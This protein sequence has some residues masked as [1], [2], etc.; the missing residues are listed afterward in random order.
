VRR[1]HVSDLKPDM[2]L[3]RAIFNDTGHLLLGAGVPI[4]ERY[5][6][7]LQA[8]GFAYVDVED[9]DTDDLEMND[10][11]SERTR[12]NVT[13]DT[14]RILS[15][16]EGVT[17]A[18]QGQDFATLQNEISSDDFGRLA[19]DEFGYEDLVA[20]LSNVVDE[21]YGQTLLPG[22]ATIRSYDSYLFLHSIDTTV[23]AVMIGKKLGFDR[24]RLHQLAAGAILHD[25]GMVT[26]DRQIVQ[27]AGRLTPTEMNAIRQHPRLGYDMLRQVRPRDVIPNHV[28]YQHHERQDGTGYPRGLQGS[29]RVTRSELE[30]HK[31]GRILL[32]A[33]I[34]A[35]ADVYDALGADRPFRAALPPDQVVRMMRALAGTHLNREIV[36]HLLQMLPVYPLGSEIVVQNGPYARYRGVVCR[37]DRNSLEHPVVRLLFD[38]RGERIDPVEVDLRR[39]SSIVIASAP[40]ARGE[41]APSRDAARA[42]AAS[43]AQPAEPAPVRRIPPV[44]PQQ[45]AQIEGARPAY[46]LHEDDNAPHTGRVLVV[47]DDPAILE[48]LQEALQDAGHTVLG[49][50]SGREALS[51]AGSSDLMLLDLGLPDMDGIDVCRALRS[52]SQ[53]ELNRLPVM[54]L[55]ARGDPLDRVR[56]IRSGADDYLA[57]PFDLAEVLVRVE[58]LLRSRQ[59][60]QALRERNRQLDALRGLIGS[61][62]EEVP[63]AQ[64]A[65]RMVDV[66]PRAFGP[67][68]GVLGAVLS[69]VDRRKGT[70]RG[71]ALTEIPS[72]HRALEMLR[73]PLTTVGSRFDPPQNLQH[74]AALTGELRAGEHLAEFVSPTLA[75]DLAGLIERTIGMKGGVAQPAK[76]HGETIALFLFLLAKPV[77]AVSATERQLMAELAQTAAVPLENARLHA[78]VEAVGGA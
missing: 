29:G 7:I 69:V 75:P 64:L 6:P 46:A 35:V 10:I 14:Y 55:T 57:K 2:V 22:L 24:N 28:A 20:D 19:R 3:A 52:A 16:M 5:I 32:D 30:K 49:A 26:V 42:P 11:I 9:P 1:I 78:A 41:A 43:A 72:A 77:T 48:V 44:A 58:A 17:R 12:L 37:V 67:D 63:V 53:P 76:S 70:I 74:Q 50:T 51:L 8:R 40:V 61:L 38:P 66:V 15:S 45:P 39:E 68:A 4:A 56:G 31:P 25:I 73:Q 47:D 71:H 60:E 18:F 36:N 54:M 34:V 27:K 59:I 23:V 33:E 13:R 65:Q 62:V 21:V